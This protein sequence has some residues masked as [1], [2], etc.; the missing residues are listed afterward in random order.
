MQNG[1]A[2]W[3]PDTFGC[4]SIIPVTPHFRA[5]S[6]QSSPNLQNK[7]PDLGHAATEFAI[8]ERQ[9]LVF[10][11]LVVIL[12]CTSFLFGGHC[13]AWQWWMAVA[14]VILVP[15]ARLEQ[16]RAA[17]RATGLFILILFTLRFLLPP[18]L[19]DIS[20]CDDMSSC[21]LPMVQ[22]L[23]EGWNPVEDPTAENI[24]NLLGLDIWGMAPLHVAFMPKTLAV[25]SAVTYTFVGDPYALTF[26]LPA[27]LWLG[28]L[29][30]AMR[31]FHGF[32][33]WALVSALVGVL[34]IVT[35]QMP[36]DLSIAYASC[37]LLLIMQDALRKGKCDWTA[38]M[39]WGAYM[40]FVKPNGA[41]GFLAFFLVFAVAS[42]RQKQM[43]RGQLAIRLATCLAL[44]MVLAVVIMWNPLGTSWRTFGHPLYPIQ[45]IDDERFPIKNLTW[46]FDVGN[47][48]FKKMG[49]AGL[50]A[51]AYISPYATVSFYRWKLNSPSFEPDALS[52]AHSEYP[53]HSVRF[54][55]LALFA[56]L[57][58]LRPGRPWAI[59]GLIILC[60]TPARYAGFTRYTPWLSSLGCLAIA[61]ASEWVET[62][63]EPRPANALSKAF[64]VTTCLL[65]VSWFWHHSRDVECFAAETKMV[66]KEIRPRFSVPQESVRSGTPFDTAASGRVD[67]LTYRDN[68]CRL[69]IKESGLDTVTRV[70]SAYEW[71]PS[72]VLDL[73]HRSKFESEESIKSAKPIDIAW[74]DRSL[75]E[76]NRPEVMT[77]R[78]NLKWKWTK[79]WIKTPFGYCV[80]DDKN[81]EFL[82]EYYDEPEEKAGYPPW[83]TFAI[84]SKKAS[85]AWFMTYPKEL[86]RRLFN[87]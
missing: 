22:L 27:F 72:D 66:R 78:M 8:F 13:A 24:V 80:P 64:S 41:F 52:W 77:L 55:L 2:K 69:L 75:W 14:V 33:K 9:V 71:L 74:G 76:N 51:H 84:R 68:Q 67:Q 18:I 31:L 56:V 42:F 34:P 30:T 1:Y 19:W 26:P 7:Y 73:L 58:L 3:L 40:T 61:F 16:W 82:H 81:A 15:F 38:L 23:I 45:T 49:K 60:L 39:T 11:L 87:R 10:P 36:V 85:H 62:R 25:F 47:E 86:K 17:L 57:I 12:A 79:G 6:L 43:G 59:A 54:G 65:V 5:E 32:P 83:K 53:K 50:F 48:D 70:F 20:E 63:L 4:A 44:L 37:G 28:V 21:H 35:W 46:D 29:L